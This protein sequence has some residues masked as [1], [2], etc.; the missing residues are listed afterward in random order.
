MP[1]IGGGS[2][3][4]GAPTVGGWCFVGAGHARDRSFVAPMGRSY[5]CVNATDSEIM[6]PGA[7]ALGIMWKVFPVASGVKENAR[8]RAP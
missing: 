4:W 8:H 7:Y 2:R 6:S 1:A 3:P 5:C